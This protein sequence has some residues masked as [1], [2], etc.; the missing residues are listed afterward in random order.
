MSEEIVCKLCGNSGEL[1]FWGILQTYFFPH[2][3]SILIMLIGLA[4]IVKIGIYGLLITGA[5]F[6]LPVV[7]ADFRMLIFPVAVFGKL[8]GKSL[9]CPKCEP[10]GKIFKR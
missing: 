8:L 9:V 10:T 7:G 1:S 4:S 5:G 3:F 6:L 2:K